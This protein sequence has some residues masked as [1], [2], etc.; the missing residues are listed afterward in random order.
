MEIKTKKIINDANECIESCNYNSPYEFEYNG[1]CYENCI[2]G[3]LNEN[4][5][6]IINKR[7]FDID[8]CLLCPNS[9]FN[10]KCTKCNIN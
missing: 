3:Y 2:N 8:K 6:N 10:K 4:N 5:N 7:K 9:N 1:K